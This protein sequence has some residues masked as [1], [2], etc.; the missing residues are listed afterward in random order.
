MGQL[1]KQ[2]TDKSSD[3]FGANTK[4]NPKE[5]CKAVMT[6]SKRFVEAKNEESVV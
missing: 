4:N 6:R 2:I 1:A 3:S 5:E